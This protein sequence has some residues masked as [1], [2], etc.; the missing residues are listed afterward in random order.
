LEKIITQVTTIMQLSNSWA[1]FKDKL[2]RLV[3][4]YNETMLLPME[5]RT[6]SG[7]GL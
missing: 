7:D 2:D 6:D 5:L 3:P 4:A 1:D